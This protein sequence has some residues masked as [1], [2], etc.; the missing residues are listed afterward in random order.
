MPISAQDRRLDSVRSNKAT[1]SLTFLSRLALDLSIN[2]LDQAQ[3]SPPS[4]LLNILTI[5][6]DTK[7]TTLPQT[8][9]R[10]QN[11]VSANLLFV[12]GPTEDSF[13]ILHGRRCSYQNMP[14]EMGNLL[15]KRNDLSPF[16][17]IG[18][19]R[20]AIRLTGRAVVLF[21]RDMGS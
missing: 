11:M 13:L 14:E 12:F 18:W 15:L 1:F 6:R 21:T 8:L 5:E 7:T 3:H 20:Y 9:E 2:A 10:H 17:R 4:L 16:L 19:I